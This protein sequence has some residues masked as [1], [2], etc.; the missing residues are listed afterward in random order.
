MGDDRC[1]R[2]HVY[3]T[4]AA[5]LGVRQPYA[6]EYRGH[7]ETGTVTPRVLYL[8][9][10]PL[11]ERP[12]PWKS[13]DFPWEHTLGGVQ[14][15]LALDALVLL[16]SPA[17]PIAAHLACNVEKSA[18]LMEQENPSTLHGEVFLEADQHE[19]CEERGQYASRL[20]HLLEDRS[21]GQTVD[22]D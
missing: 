6:V 10:P 2:A 17:V 22:G 4:L 21:R 3:N 19:D 9:R 13:L 5:P 12:D 8:Q 14:Q 15:A 11:A 18:R 16:E 7:N 1:R 20:P